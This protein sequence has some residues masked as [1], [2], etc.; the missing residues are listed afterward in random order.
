MKSYFEII[1]FFGWYF[2][3][4]IITWIIFYWENQFLGMKKIKSFLYFSLD[5]VGAFTLE[6]Y[7]YL[8]F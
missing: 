5:N 7:I 8:K 3:M 6:N 1:W 2:I 4:N